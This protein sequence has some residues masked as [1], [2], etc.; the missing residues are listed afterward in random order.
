MSV[1]GGILNWA[2]F[3][4]MSFRE[5]LLND[6]SYQR[7]KPPKSI[8]GK[9]K[10]SQLWIR[11]ETKHSF[12]HWRWDKEAQILLRIWIHSFLCI[13]MLFFQPWLNI[14]IFLPILL[15]L[16]IF[17]HHGLNYN[18]WHFHFRMHGGISCSSCRFFSFCWFVL[19]FGERKKFSDG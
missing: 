8:F 5:R 1:D 17:V 3:D 2:L 12:L 7:L 14:P 19:L 11:R 18:V 13:R 4:V 10:T 15:R 6:S 16:K 9:E